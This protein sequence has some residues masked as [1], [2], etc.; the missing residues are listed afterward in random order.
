[1]TREDKNMDN[2]DMVRSRSNPNVDQY[3]YKSRMNKEIMSKQVSI[4]NPKKE[5]KHASK[6]Q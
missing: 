3:A 5:V 1:M 6:N 2:L 4:L